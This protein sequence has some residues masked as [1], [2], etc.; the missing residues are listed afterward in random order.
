MID[1]SG[2]G[3][4]PGSPGRL[5][6]P[7][8]A[9][10]RNGETV[11]S[12]PPV[13]H[14]RPAATPMKIV[15]LDGYTANPGDLSWEPLTRLGDCHIHDRTAPAETVD[16][17]RDAAIVLTNKAPIDAATLRQ[18]PA[19]RYLGVLATGTNI[20]DTAAARA[21]GIPVCN[22]PE[23]GTASVAQA[24]F[25]L[26]L[27]LTHRVGHHADTVRAG[28]WSAAKDFSYCD[29]PLLELEGLTL[30]I[31]GYGRIGQAVARIGRA[32][33]MRILACR[34]S[35]I[36]GPEQADLETLLRSSDI[37]SLH[38]PLTPESR[39]LINAR[40]LALM[41]PTSFLVNTARGGLVHERDLADA[42]H[43]GRIAGA[44]LDVLSAEPPPADHPLIHAPRCWITP[45]LAWAT[46]AARARLIE[47]AADNVR[48]F[49]EGRPRNVV[50]P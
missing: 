30:G 2:P 36:P 1:R 37:V 14:A 22:V 46:R 32:F 12:R 11:A 27:E 28:A 6:P 47:V 43:H 42:L 29:G 50:N 35:S 16:R 41:K 20:V 7:G 45:H 10:S 24:T 17:A 26:I 9:P 3:L 21:K 15:V 44:A 31:V 19:L 48:A 5:H 40:T 33:G 25:A 49:L 13:R 23:Y 8:P 18:L 39:E 34:R 38:C 4:A